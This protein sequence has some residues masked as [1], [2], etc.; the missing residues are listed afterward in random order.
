MKRAEQIKRL[1]ELFIKCV[2]LVEK[3]G[4]DY[5]KGDD[6]FSNFTGITAITGIPTE[7]VFLQFIA[8]KILRIA[9]LIKKEKAENEPLE[10]SLIDL[11]NY[12]ALFKIYRE[13]G[14]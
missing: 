14:K 8:V 1:K 11:I 6:S 13:E 2:S 7:L 12:A 3:K 4:N 9:E 5:A 10:D